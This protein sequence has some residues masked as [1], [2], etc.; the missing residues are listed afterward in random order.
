[1]KLREKVN[2]EG[3]R[4][5]W[6]TLRSTT[7]TAVTTALQ[8][9]SSVG[10]HVQAKRKYKSVGGGKVT[11]WWFVLR[12]DEDKLKVLESEW[13]SISLQT[14]WSIEHCFR[15]VDSDSPLNVSNVS[16]IDSNDVSATNQNN[17]NHV[18]SAA[19]PTSVQITSTASYSYITQ[20]L[21]EPNSVSEINSGNNTDPFSGTPRVNEF[22]RAGREL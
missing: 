4:K 15:Y 9:L 14:Y 21:S 8:K 18:C 3:T 12:G 16:V 17:V 1:M 20:S 2:V 13:E 6:G 5:V 10:D 11:K 19:L 7:V 22:L